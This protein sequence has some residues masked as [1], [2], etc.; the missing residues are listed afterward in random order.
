MN[1]SD[2]R[3]FQVISKNGGYWLNKN[4]WTFNLAPPDMV[5]ISLPPYVEGVGWFVGEACRAKGIA[6]SL[7]EVKFSES[8]FLECDARIEHESESMGGWIYSIESESMLRSPDKKMW[9]C[10]QMKLYYERPPNT[11][12]ISVGEW[13]E[14]K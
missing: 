1:S 12:Y 8:L 13:G 3:T 4:G 5:R 2:E 10:P 6:P 11:V 9:I 7:I 14:E